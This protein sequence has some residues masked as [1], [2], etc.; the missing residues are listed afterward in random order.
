MINE[1]KGVSMI[2]IDPLSAFIAGVDSYKN[3]DVRSML[4]PLSKL[5]EKYDIAIVGVEHP[6]KSSNL[7]LLK[8]Y[9]ANSHLTCVNKQNK[10]CIFEQIII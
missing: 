9:Q 10:D 5:A 4:A 6:P 1:I 8:T 2:V 7:N 3:T